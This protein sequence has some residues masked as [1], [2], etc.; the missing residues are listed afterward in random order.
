[1]KLKRFTAEGFRNIDVCDIS[2]DGGVNLFVGGNA[3]GKTNVVEGI[4]LFARGRSFRSSDDKELIGFGKEGFRIAIE[5]EDRDGEERLEYALFGKSRQRKKNG[6]KLAGVSEM[7]GNFRAVLFFPDDL[8]LVK[9]EPEERR[10]FLNVAVSQYNKAHG[11]IFPEKER[12]ISGR[13][14]CRRRRRPVGVPHP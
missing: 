14:S 13:P 11:R 4:Y 5:Y 10:T 8:R 12:M 7:L 6:Y 2:F 3:E 1:M 9:G